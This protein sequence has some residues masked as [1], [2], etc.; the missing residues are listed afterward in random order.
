MQNPSS[1]TL[2]IPGFPASGLSFSPVYLDPSHLLP[3]IVKIEGVLPG[4]P[5]HYI[6]Q[7]MMGEEWTVKV[8]EELKKSE[9]VT[10]L[11]Y[12]KI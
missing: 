6:S 7:A 11:A 2:S 3:E 4:F 10:H 5:G 9:E 8:E 12:P 1:L